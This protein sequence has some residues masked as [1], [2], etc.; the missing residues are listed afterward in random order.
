MKAVITVTGKDNVGIIAKVS[1]LCS[2]YEANILDISQTVLQDYFAMMMLVDVSELNVNFG[3]FSDAMSKL[4]S[5]NNLI[6]NTMHEDIFNS[7]HRI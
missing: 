4:G 7:M 1:S 2:K 6:I 3:D 5:D